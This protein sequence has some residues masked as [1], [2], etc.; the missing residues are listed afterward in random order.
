M[1]AMHK[2]YINDLAGAEDALQK[3]LAVAPNNNEYRYNLANVLRWRGF[4]AR[5]NEQLDIIKLLILIT[6]RAIFLVP[7]ILLLIDSFMKR[8]N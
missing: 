4:V 1:Q 5:S 7:I 3:L 2:A 6:C 8:I